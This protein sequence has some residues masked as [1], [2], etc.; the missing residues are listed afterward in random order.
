MN[1]VIQVDSSA[2]AQGPGAGDAVDVVVAGAGVVGVATAYA[3]ARRGFSVALVDRNPGPALG[4]S[5]ANGAQL[6]YAYSDA[7][8]SPSL[9][10]K[11][12]SL[13]LGAD[14]LFR[15]KGAFDVGLVDWGL[16]F[17][18]ASTSAAN[19][20]STLAT[21][22]LGL[23]SQRAM[24]GLLERHPIAFDHLAAGKM[25]LYFDPEA[26]ASAA[27]TV[28]LKRRHGAVQEV[29]TAAEAIAIEPAL[30]GSKG[31][32][33]V[34]YSPQDEVGDPHRF[35][36][37]LID[38]L[39]RDYGVRTYFNL[40]A[41]NAEF[42][43]DAVTLVGSRGDR[44]VGR[45]LVVALGI[46]AKDFLARQGVRVPL[47]P[48]KGYSFTAAAGANAPQVS[49]TDTARKLVFCQLA[50]KVRVAG[51]AELGSRDLRV[52][53]Q[54]LAALVETARESLPDAADYSG[55]AGGWAG[56]RPMT[57][58]SVP[59]IARPRERLIVNVGHGMLGWTLAMGSAERAAALLLGAGET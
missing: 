20:A 16:R 6:S 37:Q 39:R 4:A 33:G 41:R 38:V 28:A 10:K 58:S 14:P 54:R 55:I 49:I 2:A 7:L 45:T 51:V 53:P 44:V 23:E 40:D 30:A 56:L 48:M 46:E 26:L 19:A 21:L 8:G 42:A 47:L 3:M 29:L 9:L 5:Y 13:A 35:S 32:V 12:P 1:S 50:G 52:Q 11:L 43:R 25:H 27:E 24:H 59:I 57:P 31:L 17:L 36:E 34:V 15:I 18:A 22:E